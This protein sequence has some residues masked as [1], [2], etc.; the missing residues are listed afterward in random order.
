MHSC[1]AGRVTSNPG[2]LITMSDTLPCPK[3]MLQGYPHPQHRGDAVRSSHCLRPQ[4]GEGKR[5]SQVLARAG[6]RAEFT[7]HFQAEQDML[8]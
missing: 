5:H 3:R 8:H 4:K 2:E 7:Q 1:P 6:K